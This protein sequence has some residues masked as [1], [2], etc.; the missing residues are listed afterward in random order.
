MN[1]EARWNTYLTALTQYAQR[2]G[3]TRVPTKHTE[4]I[5]SGAIN[6]GTWVSYVRQRNKAGL[7]PA[8]RKE[9]LSQI[10]GWEWTAQRPGLK[11][12][13]GR[14]DA[15]RIMRTGGASLQKIGDAY[16]LSRQRVF[17]ILKGGK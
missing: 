10:Q 16:H 13:A 8:S 11:T 17:Q 15:I 9:Q 7:L 12:E 3:H 6:L 4:T 1:N 14:D 5:E 2:E